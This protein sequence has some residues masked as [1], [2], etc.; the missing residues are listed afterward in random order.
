MVRT[1]FEE[2]DMIHTEMS[3]LAAALRSAL[4]PCNVVIALALNL[5][6]C[7]VGDL[8]SGQKCG[9]DADCALGERCNVDEQICV[10]QELVGRDLDPMDGSPGDCNGGSCLEDGARRTLSAPLPSAPG[11]FV[12]TFET[13][14]GRILGQMRPAQ[15][16]LAD[17]ACGDSW[18]EVA[19]GTPS[20]NWSRTAPSLPEHRTE[21]SVD[22]PYGGTYHVSL[23]IAAPSEAQDALY[24]G[25]DRA[26]MRRVYPPDSYPYNQSWVWVSAVPGASTRLVFEGLSAGP[27]TLV[28]AHGEAGIRCDKV[29]VADSPSP[30]FDRTCDYSGCIDADGDGYGASC[31][32]GADCDDDNPAYNVTCPFVATIEAESANEVGQMTARQGSLADPA[33]GNAWVEVAAGTPDFFWN[34]AT[35]ALPAHRTEALGVDL[36]AA[37]T[38]YVSLRLAAP[39]G[40]ADALY[41]GFSTADMRRIDLPAA[42]AYDNSWAWISAVDGAP[43]RLAFTGLPAGHQTLIIAHGEAGV[44]CDKVV[45]ADNPSATFE[46]GCGIATCIDAD[47]DGFGVHC[48]LG[49]DCDDTSA[50]YN[51]ACPF[52]AS[53]EAEGGN[54]LGQMTATEGL[55]ADPA[56][57]DAWVEV[58]AGV[59]SFSWNAAAPSL[60]EHRTELSV[61]LPAAGTYYVSLRLAAPAGTADALYAGFS[62]S[63]LRRVYLPDGYAYDDS[64]QWVSAVPGAPDR[65]V[66]EDLSAGRHT[67]IVAH[68]EAGVRCDKV[69]IADSPSASFDPSCGE[70]RAC[71]DGDTDSRACT[72]ANGAGTQNRTCSGGAWQAFGSCAVTSCDAGYHVDGNGCVADSTGPTSD[73][74]YPF[75]GYTDTRGAFEVDD[76]R[77]LIVDDLE[78]QHLSGQRSGG[79][80]LVAVGPDANDPRVILFEISG[81]IDVGDRS[82]SVTSPYVSVHGQTAPAPGSP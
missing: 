47:G 82:L 55:L 71:S 41:V 77:I 11:T 74:H 79:A 3:T 63:D 25:F 62:A 48:T 61:D 5:G 1:H 38:Y 6:G 70:A 24:V 2:P 28:I 52:V 27:H 78:R 40:T 73:G 20:F 12:A 68:G 26:D 80:W 81:V 18:V 69:V 36:P 53:L 17:P 35:P 43:E 19:T 75:Q 72:V 56:C 8:V 9:E 22:L 44:R 29:V 14:L 76:P 54:D 21:L 46:R 67:F 15:G 58:A 4:A 32:R 30:S 7:L 45:V 42:Y 16:L 34:T 13:E 66:F 51:V 57:G 10:L 31:S 33:C 65:L 49:E 64:W 39:A 37:G 23:R 59:A 60:P 50:I